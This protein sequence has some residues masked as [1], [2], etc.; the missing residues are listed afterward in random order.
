MF[1]CQLSSKVLQL[2][3]NIAQFKFF[4]ICAKPNNDDGYR[5]F[6]V[7]KYVFIVVLHI[8]AQTIMFVTVEYPLIQCIVIRSKLN[9]RRR[10]NL[11]KTLLYLV[12]ETACLPGFIRLF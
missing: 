6:T 4:A 10:F 1:I 11:W 12:L 7:A 2:A 8:R 5:L 9:L 3:I